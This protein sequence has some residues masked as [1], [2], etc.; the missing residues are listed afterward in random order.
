MTMGSALPKVKEMFSCL[1]VPKL[2]TLPGGEV[3]LEGGKI[4]RGAVVTDRNGC[5]SKRVST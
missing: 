3:H 2:E 1:L 4:T 5:V